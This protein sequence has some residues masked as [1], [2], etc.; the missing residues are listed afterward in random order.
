MRYKANQDYK[1]DLETYQEEEK[2]YSVIYHNIYGPNAIVT[3]TYTPDNW[4]GSKTINDEIVLSAFGAD[5]QQF[6]GHFTVN[7]LSNG[8]ACLF[9]KIGK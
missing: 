2:G 5:W 3:I 8:E 9:E 7:G 1:N 4:I 6:F